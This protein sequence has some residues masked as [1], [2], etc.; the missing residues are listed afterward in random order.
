MDF[1]YDEPDGD[2]KLSSG[3]TVGVEV[4]EPET[5]DGGG[6]PLV[7]VAVAGVVV[8]LAAGAY[9]RYGR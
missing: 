4:T 6:P 8:L 1:Q 9:L 7:L 2:T 5:D 3:Y